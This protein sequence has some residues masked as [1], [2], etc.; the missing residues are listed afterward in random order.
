MSR[1]SRIG[2]LVAASA[3]QAGGATAMLP[4]IVVWAH[5]T[6]GLHGAGAGVLF[7][8]QAVGEFG[9]GMFVGRIAD[10]WGRRRILIASTI[11]MAIGYGLLTVTSS[12]AAA[13]VLFLAAGVVESAFHPCVGALV[14][15]IAAPS[16]QVGAFGSVRVG[17]NVG[18]ILGPLL[19]AWVATIS[20]SLV[21]GV[22]GALFLAAAAVLLVFL[23]AEVDDRAELGD[24]EPEVPPGTL[25]ALH[26]DRGLLVLVVSGG[27]VGIAFA[28]FQS[29][30]LVLLRQQTALS[31]AQYALLFTVM[32]I[33]IIA[34]QV[35]IG[36]WTRRS[37]PGRA[38][39]LGGSLQG[40]GLA[41]L[42]FAH[43]GYGVLIG[44]AV[45]MAVG[46]ATYSPVLSAFVSRRAGATRRASYMAALSITEDIGS[47]I[48]PVSGLA[49]AGTN[50]APFL[51]ALGAMLS[52]TAGVVNARVASRG[53]RV[54][55]PVV[56]SGRHT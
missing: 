1:N 18:R 55:S 48:G 49:I 26:R 11:G 19:G 28:W 52:A 45:L 20:T 10:R 23:P 38:M 15:D 30:G 50:R 6:A 32:A 54:E 7:V 47:A 24:A 14:G 27:V 51:W 16:G 39:L 56:G 53:Q 33:V 2:A 13:V 22:V 3:L 12:P 4:F 31:E 40:A 8:V 17:S 37:R 43:V 36:R 25:T 5:Q 41:C 46:E 42:L 34:A 44:A 29:D 21:F 9:A 35:P